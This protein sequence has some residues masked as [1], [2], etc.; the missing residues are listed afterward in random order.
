M[1]GDGVTHPSTS[2][3]P[4]W[5]GLLTTNDWQKQWTD[6]YNMI[7]L[8]LIYSRAHGEWEWFYYA[9]FAD[10]LHEST[11]STRSAAVFCRSTGQETMD[12]T[13]AEG[14]I[15]NRPTFAISLFRRPRPHTRVTKKDNSRIITWSGAMYIFIF[16]LLTQNRATSTSLSH[17]EGNRTAQKIRTSQRTESCLLYY[18]LFA[19]NPIQ[20]NFF[21]RFQ[22][23]PRPH[24]AFYHRF[25]FFFFGGGGGG[26]EGADLRAPPF[27]LPRR[28]GGR[29]GARGQP[30][31]RYFRVHWMEAW[32]PVLA[33][34]SAR[35]T[36]MLPVLFLSRWE[37]PRD[38]S[39][40]RCFSLSTWSKSCK[41]SSRFA[42][43][44]SS[45]TP[46]A[47]KGEGRVFHWKKHSIAAHKITK[48]DSTF[49][50]KKY[51]Y[52]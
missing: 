22:T 20:E 48:Q 15:L 21:F 8:M 40:N 27:R 39:S 47:F 16:A 32:S 10:W 23:F 17:S 19:P 42:D 26:G 4:F 41:S 1:E 25:F 37:S 43:N 9:E 44:S 24:V 34:S 35:P 36:P 14:P 30:S 46:R 38:Q 6:T 29:L 52:I 33:D 12:R 13:C 5:R 31:L 51:I 7:V 28:Q 49:G 3:K 50:K 45:N 11:Q 2:K 18:R